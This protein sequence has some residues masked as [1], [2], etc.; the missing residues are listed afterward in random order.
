MQR[1]SRTGIIALGILVVGLGSTPAVAQETP[2]PVLNTA[3]FPGVSLG[4]ICFDPI[5]NQVYVVDFVTN[6]THFYTP[7][8]TYLGV[9]PSAFPP[10]TSVTG[11]TAEPTIGGVIWSTVD[12][13]T[14]TQSIFAAPTVTTPPTFIAMIGGAPFAGIL[15]I[16]APTG[17]S[18][19]L[20]YN[21][22]VAMNTRFTDY[23]GVPTFG[24]V[25]TPG[26]VS[27]GIS[28]YGGP[29]VAHSNFIAG[30]GNGLLLT[31]VFT[32]LA[33]DL[34]GVLL[35]PTGTLSVGFDF[36]PPTAA[37]ANTIYFGDSTTNVLT[38]AIVQRTFLRGD[39][40]SDGAFNVAD[41]VFVLG[42]LF[43]G[44]APPICPDAA[45]ANDDGTVNIAD[46][47]SMLMTLFGGGVPLPPPFGA[48]G[49]DPTPD[50]NRCPLSSTN[51][52]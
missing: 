40:N 13:V 2:I 52:P 3:T 44:G 27:L 8:L 19:A 45:D 49:Y 38:Q 15:G 14:A 47:A 9:A 23:F 7:N 48:C 51:C 29:F 24:P 26:G 21:D 17:L 18:N 25:A 43:S 28:Y 36:G 16:D 30:G 46:A 20:L 1:F 11:I 4:D 33:V 37:G 42:A 6:D 12:T 10:N 5:A 50:P 31:D 34:V 41:P 35:S 32:G 39:A 22:A